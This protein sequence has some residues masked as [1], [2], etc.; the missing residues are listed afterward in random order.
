MAIIRAVARLPY[1]TGI[2]EDVATNTFYYE[3]LGSP[4]P[5]TRAAIMDGVSS[6]YDTVVVG[7]AVGAYMAAYVSRAADACEVELY[8]L[9]D[10]LPRQ[11]IDRSTFTMPAATGTSNLA[12]E[13]AVCLSFRGLYVSGQPNARRR[14]RVFIGPLSGAAV[15]AATASTFPSPLGAFVTD[16]LDGAFDFLATIPDVEGATW[17]V[18]SPSD[19]VA[20]PV[21]EAWVDNAFDTQRRRGN[22]PASRVT[23]NI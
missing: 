7:A 19:G 6:F 14:G 4:N 16:L 1:F 20:R 10:P 18:Y 9:T 15:T 11:P 5:A 12:A 2:P 17:S 22:A 8:D 23:R 21:V 3:T 13:T